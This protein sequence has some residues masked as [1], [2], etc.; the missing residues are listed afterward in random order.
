MMPNNKSSFSDS[1][2][3]TYYK[4]LSMTHMI[5]GIWY[6]HMICL[7]DICLYDMEY[8]MEMAHRIR[9][10]RAL[11]WRGRIV[12]WR[13]KILTISYSHGD[14]GDFFNV[15]TR[16]S[17]FQSFHP[18]KPSP[19]SVTNIDAAYKDYTQPLTRSVT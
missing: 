7:H 4:S 19:P 13:I 3:L 16:L 18:Q 2:I 5:C 10:L 6:A 11:T 9:P 17:T 14:V 12:I 8:N 1:S 15:E